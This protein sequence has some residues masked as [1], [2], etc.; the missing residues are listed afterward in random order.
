MIYAINDRKCINNPGIVAQTLNTRTLE[1]EDHELKASLGYK[2]SPKLTLETV[3]SPKRKR[4]RRKRKMDRKRGM[5]R[6]KETRTVN[7]KV[8]IDK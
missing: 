1:T 5:G 7:E 3:V 8:Q 2:E 6:K 4:R